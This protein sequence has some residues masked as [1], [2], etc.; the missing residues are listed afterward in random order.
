MNSVFFVQEAIL[1]NVIIAIHFRIMIRIAFH[2]II[3]FSDTVLQPKLTKK[4]CV[5]RVERQDLAEPTNRYLLEQTVMNPAGRIETQ[6]LK[7]LFLLLRIT[8]S[9]ALIPF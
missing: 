8:I 9:I 7:V 2:D 3:H 5:S 4:K 6:M 1:Q